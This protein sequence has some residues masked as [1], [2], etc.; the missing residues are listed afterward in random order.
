MQGH[1]SQSLSLNDFNVNSQALMAV[2]LLDTGDN[3]TSE[4]WF[5]FVLP[6]LVSLRITDEETKQKLAR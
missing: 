5:L 4:S 6:S 3:R 1:A 2:F